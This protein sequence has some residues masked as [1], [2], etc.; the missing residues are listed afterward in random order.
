MTEN[1]HNQPGEDPRERFRRLL[2]EAE[3]AEKE[4][5]IPFEVD[6]PEATQS[7]VLGEA[8]LKTPSTDVS[9]DR[10]GLSTSLEES[11]L[12]WEEFSEDVLTPGGPFDE[13]PTS[14][15][16]LSDTPP[17]P[18]LGTT[19]HVSPPAVDTRGMPL[20][21]R[22]DEIDVDAT[23]VSPAAYEPRYKKKPVVPPTKKA[24]Q[25]KPG[26]PKSGKK[27]INIENW[28]GCF[29]RMSILGLFGFA[30]IG[31]VSGSLML[32]WYYSIIK[33]E[34]WPDVG[35][36]Y[37]RTSQFETTRILDRN[38]NLLYE[39]MDPSAGRRSYVPLDEI[40]PYLIAAT[41]ATED[42][43]FYSHP[44]FDPMAIV[45]AFGQNLSSGD[46]V[47]G[48]STITQQ[49]AKSLFL[50]SEERAQGTYSRKVKEA[51]LAAELTR[52]YTK[53]EILELYVNEIYYGN[54]TYGIE[55]ASQTYFGKS[56][57]NL[58]LAQASFLAGL[59]QLPGIY[60][61]Y[62]NREATLSR[63]Q[64]VLLL[65][66]QTS[67]EQGCIY[68]SN[69]PQPICIEAG[70][71]AEAAKEIEEYEFS[72][73]DIKIR[74]PHW[75][76]FVR[77]QLEEQFDPQTIYRSGFTVYTTL[78]PGLQDAAIQVV[79]DQINLLA[80]RHVTNGALVAIRPASG[81]ILAM[82]GS[83]DFYNESI[84]GQVNMAISPRQ[85][86]SSIKP[87]TY[88]AA[89]ERGWTPSTLLWDVR[90]EFP[91]SGDPND[92][93]DPYVPV[94]YDERYHGPVTVRAA[95]AN[96]YNIPAVKTLQ[97]VGIYDNPST[98]DEDGMI[99]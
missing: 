7:T 90:S 82:V 14:A 36:L 96:S 79:Q 93:R 1:K 12:N 89:F 74:Y 64:D 50:T 16:Q 3:K 53:D 62:T 27:K 18:M 54:L 43:E 28:T 83:A 68:V 87:I 2:E 52:L 38:G 15:Q 48:A 98:P 77:G 81:E 58:N 76:N 75:V 34:D 25:I 26:R 60:D 47:S 20:P 30:I 23:R 51:L 65:I 88:L 71:A 39:I 80:D 55:A 42:K 24:P 56:A 92:P 32:F 94:N 63:H 61:I 17:P 66:F 4:A 97:F 31:I 70:K 9:G 72:P 33:A 73:P 46:T 78:D 69:N 8:E 49:L 41:L 21:R 67:Q 10:D 19:P 57:K 35:E 29:L 85:P 59:P 22:V 6:A 11:P 45:R 95:L 91:P 13:T 99:A 40:S 37:Q 84:D 44:G 86:G 5:T